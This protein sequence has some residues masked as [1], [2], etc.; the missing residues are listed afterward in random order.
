MIVLST[1]VLETFVDLKLIQGTLT[2]ELLFGS[3][4][5]LE[6][7]FLFGQDTTILTKIAHAR[8]IWVDFSSLDFNG[9][10]ISE[11]TLSSSGLFKHAGR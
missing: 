2:Q 10:G 11:T 3:L 9:V 7:Q 6:Y 1:I 5:N 4:P 8:L